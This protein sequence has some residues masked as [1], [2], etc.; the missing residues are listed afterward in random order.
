VP[1]NALSTPRH[2]R[3]RDS[4]VCGAAIGL[5]A[6]DVLHS[7]RFRSGRRPPIAGIPD[8]EAEAGEW[9]GPT[10]SLL[11]TWRHRT[12]AGDPPP[13]IF[14][15][16]QI[17]AGRANLLSGDVQG[18]H[19]WPRWSQ[20]TDR[21]FSFRSR[22][23]SIMSFPKSAR[24]TPKKTIEKW[25]DALGVARWQVDRV[26]SGFGGPVGAQQADGR[27]RPESGSDG[28]VRAFAA[29]S[30]DNET[31]LLAYAEGRR[32][33]THE[34]TWSTKRWCGSAPVAGGTPIARFGLDSH[35]D[36][37][38]V[39]GRRTGTLAA[40]SR[41]SAGGIRDSVP[42]ARSATSGQ[43]AGRATAGSPHRGC[44]V[45]DHHLGG[46][47]R[48]DG[49]RRGPATSRT[50]GSFHRARRK[51]PAWRTRRQTHARESSHVEGWTFGRATL[52]M[53]DHVRLGIAAATSTSS[54]ARIDGG[55]ADSA[56]ETRPS[57]E[58]HPSWGRRTAGLRSPYPLAER[59]GGRRRR[60]ADHTSTRGWAPDGTP[61]TMC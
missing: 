5:W 49:I 36:V 48:L 4:V 27:R 34:L 37:S 9:L 22:T 47:V 33:P 44:G 54:K 11:R 50:S 32:P 26:S 39:M 23:V 20:P 45:H 52:P 16:L 29:W 28:S 61:A 55:E 58:F 12:P 38:P 6:F 15:R 53:G 1:R 57:N 17:D 19:G 59:R 31:R 24:C 51:P 3:N 42:A 10:E 40:F 30:P 35:Q 2:R 56:H 60:H 18:G 46:R 8:L 41:S 14:V 13:R 43:A 21:G 7:R 25:D